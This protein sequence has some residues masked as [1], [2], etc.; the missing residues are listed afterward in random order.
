MI[1]DFIVCSSLEELLKRRN[2]TGSDSLLLAGGTEVLRLEG[3]AEDQDVCV[4]SLEGLGLDRIE[5][6]DLGIEIGA[7]VTLQRL[8]DED[9][10]PLWLKEAARGAGSRTLRNMATIGGNIAAFRDDSYLIPA[11]IAAKARIITADIREDGSVYEESVPIREYVEHQKEFAGSCIVRVILNHE[12]RSVLTRR[13]SRTVQRT[14]D[15]IAAF[16]ALAENGSLSDVRV[17]AAGSGIGIVRLQQLEDGIA[18]GSVR[19]LEQIRSLVER[20]V[21]LTDSLTGSAGYRTYLIS[22]AIEDMLSA[23]L[24]EAE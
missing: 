7:M 18:D 22:A 10:V 23:C 5:K 4:Y 6:T 21:K 19:S 16:G 14:P 12:N 13:Y 24:S 1:Q 2:E 3:R 17:I 20:S 15:V 11:C 9:L 8:L